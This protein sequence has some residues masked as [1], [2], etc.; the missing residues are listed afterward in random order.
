VRYFFIKDHLQS[1]NIK[2]VYCPLECM[3]A[4]FFTK[5]LQGKLF[6]YLKAIVMGHEPLETMTAQFSSENQELVVENQKSDVSTDVIPCIKTELKYSHNV[7][8]TENKRKPNDVRK[9]VS[10]QPQVLERSRSYAEVVKD[11]LQPFRG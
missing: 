1:E 2:V 7:N 8:Q 9:V 4:D 3:V 5:P 11:R 10:F 6:H